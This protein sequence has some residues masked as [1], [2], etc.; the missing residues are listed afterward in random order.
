ME[1]MVAVE[2]E[3]DELLD[4][5]LVCEPPAP[6]EPQPVRSARISNTPVQDTVFIH[7]SSRKF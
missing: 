3:F 2:V 7:I 4:E 1:V 5:V 6:L